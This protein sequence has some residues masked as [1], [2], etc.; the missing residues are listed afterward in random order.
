MVNEM[1]KPVVKLVGADGNVFVIIGLCKTAA[2]KAGWDRERIAK[3]QNDMMHADSY[4]AV[5]T[6]ATDNFE[7]E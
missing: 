7:V 4:D 3:L 1:S 5:L 6:M 2:R